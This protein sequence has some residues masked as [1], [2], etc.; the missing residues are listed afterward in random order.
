MQPVLLLPFWSRVPHWL[1]L[2][3]YLYTEFCGTNVFCPNTNI[4]VHYYIPFF[5]SPLL[6]CIT[7]NIIAFFPC[8]TRAYIDV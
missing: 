1:D 2:M 3:E 6:F 5:V 8:Q 7:S 4:K